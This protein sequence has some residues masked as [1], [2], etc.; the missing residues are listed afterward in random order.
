MK[1]SLHQKLL[2][3]LAVLVGFCAA[4]PTRAADYPTTVLSL[5]PGGYYRLSETTPNVTDNAINTGT[6]G[7]LGNGFYINSPAHPLP[8]IVPGSHNGALAASATAPIKYVSVPLNAANNPQGAFTAECWVQGDATLTNTLYSVMTQGH[9]QNPGNA[10]NRSGWLLYMDG[11]GSSSG[12]NVFDYRMYNHNGLSRSLTINGGGTPQLATHTYHVVVGYDGANGFMYVDGALVQSSPS[13]GFYHDTD[14]NF[15]VGARNDEAFTFTGLISDVAYYTNVLSAADV[16]S[17]YQTGTNASSAPGAYSALVLSKNPI[18]YFQFNEPA[19]SPASPLQTTSNLGTWGHTYDAIIQPGVVMGADGPVAGG[20]P[21]GNKAAYIPGLRSASG[22]EYGIYIPNPPMNTDPTNGGCVTFT[23]WVKR[24]GP[25]EDAQGHLNGDFAGIVFER[26]ALPATGLCFG[27]QNGT[28]LPNN[29]LRYHWN[30]T[31][32]TFDAG[33]AFI[34]PDQVWSFVAGVF[35]PSNTVLCLNGVFAMNAVSNAPLDFSADNLYFGVDNIGGTPAGGRVMDGTIDEVAIFTN[36]LSTNQ[37]TALYNAAAILPTITQQPQPPST[38]EYEGQSIS[39]SVAAIGPQPITYQWQK[40]GAPISGQ[41][42]TSFSIGNAHISDTGNYAVK[43]TNPS[44]SVTSSVVSL[45]VLGGPPILTG[46]PAS[47]ARYVDGNASF[48]V[49]AV[50]S[51]PLSYQWSLGGTAIPGAT[52]STLTIL[53]LQASDFGNYSVRVTNP[54]GSSNSPPATLS[55]LTLSPTIVPAILTYNPFAYYRLN[56]TS[57]TVAYDSVGGLD[58]TFLPA[59]THNGLPGPVPPAFPGLDATNTCFSFDGNTSDINCKSPNITVNGITITAFIKTE[60]LPNNNNGGACGVVFTR[61]SGILGLNLSGLSAT[62]TGGNTLSY[63]WNNVFY[64]FTIT[65]PSNVWAFVALVVNSNSATM[66]YDFQDGAGLQS[67]VTAGTNA[68]QTIDAPIHLGTDP[69]G[70][71]IYQGLLDEVAVFS[72]DLSASAIQAI[73]DAAFTNTFTPQPPAITLDPVGNTSL[74]G[75]DTYTMT[76]AASGSRPLSFQWQK[77]GVNIPGAIRETLTLSNV[78]PNDNGSYTFVATQGGTSVTSAPAVITVS[79]II[80][81]Q[82]PGG[83]GV[84]VG[85]SYTMSVA[86]RGVNLTYQWKKNGVNIAGATGA[87]FT[88]ASAGGGDGGTYTCVITSGIYSLTSSPA[89]VTLVSPGY[90]YLTNGLVL[91]LSFDTAFTDSSGRGNDAVCCASAGLQPPIISPGMVGAGAVEIDNSSFLQIPDPHGDLSF[92]VG[93]SFSISLWLRYTN[94][95]NDLPVIGNA[96][97]STY[98]LGFVITEDQHQF[99]VS[100]ADAASVNTA[101]YI[102]DPVGPPIISGNGWHNLVVA[103]DR[104]SAVANAYIDGT[105][106]NSKSMA[107]MGNINT[108]QTIAM[109]QDPTLAYGTIGTFD[110]DDV[111]IWRTVLNASAAR[112]LYLAGE[113]G[114]SFDNPGPAPVFVT[115]G[116][117]GGNLQVQYSQGTLQ[118]AGS[119]SGPYTAVPGA[120]APTYTR[121]LP[122]TNIFYRVKVQ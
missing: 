101:R 37:L 28:P 114:R 66:Y 92:N 110:V 33:N 36:A 55:Q 68:A 79:A 118:S 21:A 27:G 52:G 76:A 98:Q 71:R 121:P 62:G 74:A 73:H 59:T 106:V 14:G 24:N 5:N 111:G 122:A 43:L 51:T 19:F 99:E 105:F 80:I 81:T 2:L 29:Q 96:V 32:Y 22:A 67:V 89:V 57:G 94:E 16:L 40:N 10:P 90:A 63:T 49:T 83:N 47:A 78:S 70:N 13:P 30:N 95:F 77:N 41:T 20:F 45:T 58:G 54:N 53:S 12:G 35:T 116:V 23:A 26:G 103:L 4:S 60:G 93:D 64:D 15:T 82:Q 86:A 65:A 46:L 18:I 107:G 50:G 1:K 6:I 113:A 39:Y 112:S 7:A 42:T 11:D 108:G 91:H 115:I 25:S 48:T 75:G 97:N 84:L 85:G 31:D 9:L 117:V 72:Y 34:I 100:F 102:M 119:A 109:G 38:T 3:P 17:H 44:G 56:E 61:G 69:S 120:S 104:G 88:I 8:S 87:S